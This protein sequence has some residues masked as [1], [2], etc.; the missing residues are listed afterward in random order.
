M[1]TALLI[2]LATVALIALVDFIPRFFNAAKKPLK[3]RRARGRVTDYL[4][5]PTIYGDIS[6]LKNLEFLKQYANRVVICTSAYESAEFY[7]AL[8]AICQAHGLRYIT[9]DLPHAG[10]KPIKNA[11]TIYKGAFSNL[12]V[13]G[14]TKTTPCLLID[15]DTISR[16]NVNDLVR[17]FVRNNCDVASLRCEAAN[18]SNLLEILQEYEYRTAMDNRRMDPWLTSGA[19]N[20]ARADTFKH[21][22]S[23]HS[24]F[25]AGGDIEIGKLAQ[26]MGYHIRHIDFTFYTEIPSTFRDWFNQ[27]IIWMA[28]G[29]TASRG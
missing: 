15:A 6:Y 25:F 12:D 13:L 24:H 18:T 29:G 26:T 1:A 17:T 11:Y 5:M 8:D 9:V 7:S 10:G 2:L 14:A 21:V 20:M 27:R 16:S 23:R 22:F 28:G 4:I 3:V 19:C